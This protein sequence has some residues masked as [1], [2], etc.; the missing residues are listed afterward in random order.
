MCRIFGI[1]YGPD[2]PQAEPWTPSEMLQLMFPSLTAGGPDA[3]GW[4]TWDGVGEEVEIYK[5][6]GRAD[7]NEALADMEIS[8]NV[9][10]IVGHTRWAT[11]GSVDNYA[12]NHPIVHGDIVGVHNGIV[13]NYEEILDQTGRQDDSAEVDSEA[14][15]AAIE[16]WGRRKGL[17]KLKGSMASAFVDMKNLGVINL[18]RSTGRPLAIARTAGGSLIF[19]SV[20]EAIVSMGL[21]LVES[22]NV[23]AFKLLRVELGKVTQRIQW[24]TES[25]QRFDKPIPSVKGITDQYDRNRRRNSER[26]AAEQAAMRDIRAAAAAKGIKDGDEIDGLLYHN[27]MLVTY[28]EFRRAVRKELE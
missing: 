15:F 14:I 22:Y 17:L 1:I 3:Y 6:V 23:G 2:G 9:R 5:G 7:S 28:E 8:D 19:A 10:W 21:D 11:H 18:A 4:M 24:K 27:G 25:W 20:P 16:K 13:P 26:L 12:N